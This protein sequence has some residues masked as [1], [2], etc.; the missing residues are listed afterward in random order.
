MQNCKA[1]SDN[2]QSIWSNRHRQVSDDTRFL[3]SLGRTAHTFA[4]WFQVLSGTKK[5]VLFFTCNKVV[6]KNQ[7]RR[8]LEVLPTWHN[9][10]EIPQNVPVWSRAMIRGAIFFARARTGTIA[11]WNGTRKNKTSELTRGKVPHLWM[12]KEH[13][14]LNSPFDFFILHEFFSW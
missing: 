9:L 8:N 1:K 3:L 13:S 5:F 12:S 14:F 11:H 6:Q 7:V 4:H 2:Y 10:D